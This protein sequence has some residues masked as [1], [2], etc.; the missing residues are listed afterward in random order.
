MYVQQKEGYG[1][2]GPTV[3]W[4]RVPGIKGME[5]MKRPVLHVTIE[6]TIWENQNEIST[7]VWLHQCKDWDAMDSSE[8]GNSGGHQALCKV[9]MDLLFFLKL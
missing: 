9:Q 1:G 4:G 6:N 2:C 5:A 8:Q 7:T 3:E